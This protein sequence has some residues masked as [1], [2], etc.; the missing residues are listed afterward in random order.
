MPFAVAGQPAVAADPC[1]GAFH[2][3]AFRQHDEAMQVVPLDGL[4]APR[5]GSRD[6]CRHLRSLTAAIG[7]D[8]LDAGEAAAGLAQKVEGAV[9]VLHI[10]REDDDVQQETERID[11]DVALAARDFL[12]RVEALRIDRR[13]PFRAPLVLW[14]SMTATLGLASRPACSRLAI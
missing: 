9:A 3:P 5:A 12:A 2:D 8:A 13:P 10:R 11:E 6:G 14:L 4:D 1:K 7:E